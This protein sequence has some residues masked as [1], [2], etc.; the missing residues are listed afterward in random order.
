MPHPAH[1]IRQSLPGAGRAVEPGR[2]DIDW[3]GGFKPRSDAEAE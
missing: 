2:E 1:S 3:C